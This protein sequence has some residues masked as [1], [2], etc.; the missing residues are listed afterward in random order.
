MV[1]CAV[2][3]SDVGFTWLFACFSM[4]ILLEFFFVLL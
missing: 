3:S 1:G 2:R 4:E